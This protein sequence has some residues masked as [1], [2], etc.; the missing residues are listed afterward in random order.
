MEIRNGL[1]FIGMGKLPETVNKRRLQ[2][3]YLFNN[4]EGQCFERDIRLAREA[5]KADLKSLSELQRLT[6][7]GCLG[8]T[9]YRFETPPLIFTL[10]D[11]KSFELDRRRTCWSMISSSWANQFLEMLGDN[12]DKVIFTD[13][14]QKLRRCD[15]GEIYLHWQ[16]LTPINQALAMMREKEQATIQ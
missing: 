1:E 14:L 9:L 8:L 2:D 16:D 4:S 10:G 7:L 15:R 6:W 5:V 12:I 3:D 11:D 13:I